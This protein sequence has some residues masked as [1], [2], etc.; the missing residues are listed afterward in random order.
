LKPRIDLL[1]DFF[2]ENRWSSKERSDF[3]W[4][5]LVSGF[6]QDLNR[7]VLVCEKYP[8]KCFVS[9][10]LADQDFNAALGNRDRLSPLTNAVHVPGGARWNGEKLIS[11]IATT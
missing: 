8:A 5:K 3:Q 11:R 9:D 1:S 10:E 2:P 7:E 6:T 4:R